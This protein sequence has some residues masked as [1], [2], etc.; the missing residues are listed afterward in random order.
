[1]VEHKIGNAK[2]FVAGVVEE[3][4]QTK[5]EDAIITPANIQNFITCATEDILREVKSDMVVS[6]NTIWW[7]EEVRV[8]I[9]MKDVI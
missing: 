8:A 1:M 6:K 9:E 2:I 7:D 5:E 3:A 4:D